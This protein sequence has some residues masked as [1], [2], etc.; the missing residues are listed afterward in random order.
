MSKYLSYNGLCNTDLM[1][2]L[3]PKG[4]YV[5]ACFIDSVDSDGLRLRVRVGIT[6]SVQITKEIPITGFLGDEFIDTEI[7]RVISE[8][9]TA[10]L[11]CAPV[12]VSEYVGKDGNIIT[13][14]LLKDFYLATLM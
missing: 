6:G 7:E 2:K 13:L 10:L 3:V 4:I 14:K 12:S 1:E 11:E 9:L 5:R 8:C